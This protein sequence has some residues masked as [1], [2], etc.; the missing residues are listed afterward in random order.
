MATRRG[1]TPWQGAGKS[2]PSGS[3][4]GDV[5]VF[6]QFVEGAWSRPPSDL[7]SWSP[8]GSVAWWTPTGATGYYHTWHVNVWS[9]TLTSSLLSSPPP[10]SY[11]QLT[12]ISD[13]AGVGTVRTGVGAVPARPGGGVVSVSRTDS[14][15]ASDLPPGP[16]WQTPPGSLTQWSAQGQSTGRAV[17]G[18]TASSS[19]GLAGGGLQ[20]RSVALEMLP[21]VGPSSPLVLAPDSGSEVPSSGTVGFEWQH[22]PA[23]SGGYQDAY[24]W[25]V[26]AGAGWRYWSA[27][28]SSFVTSEATNV[29]GVQALD[30]SASLFTA[31][32]RHTWQVQTREGVDG[33]WSPWSPAATFTPVTPPSVTLTG[34]SSWHDDLTP[35]ITWASTTPRGQQTAFQVQ[36]LNAA[37]A[38]VVHDSRWQP[39]SATSWTV[40]PLDWVNGAAYQRRVRVQQ[41]GGAVSPWAED[42]L[43]VSWTEPAT[44]T[45]TATPGSRGVEVSVEVAS[46]MAVTLERIGTDGLWSPVVVAAPAS[47]GSP[48][49]V[50]DVYAPYRAPTAYR[51]QGV[52]ELDGQRL[53]SG[54][55]SSPPVAST[56]RRGAYLSLAANPTGTWTPVTITLLDHGEMHEAVSA[57]YGLGDSF[58]RVAYGGQQGQ[59]GTITLDTASDL[60]RD[61]LLR[62]LSAQ[63]A[64]LLRIPPEMDQLGNWST[65]AL[66]TIA[67][68]SPVTTERYGVA[69]SQSRRLSFSWVEQPQVL[70][71]GATELPARV[72]AIY[73]DGDVVVFG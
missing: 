58:G 12:V 70:L 56:D 31:Q 44:P 59:A 48:L 41:T 45:V 5:A 27:S 16:S 55:A 37:S 2:W 15:S 69:P 7:A 62:M 29:S 33:K 3:S 30:L 51:A 61:T 20:G 47:P 73:V 71:D 42:A 22:R 6:V 40:P 35:T 18:F 34:P 66:L 57:T 17:V 43:T 14:S 39:G 23:V 24:R 9:R 50:T 65:G 4:P 36:V 52:V 63:T 26:D 10:S 32:A 8:A 49:V 68:S 11:G 38:A 54:W 46:S 60:A 1:F 72:P 64:M 25:R 28:T 67:R 13:T 53:T 19:G 21:P